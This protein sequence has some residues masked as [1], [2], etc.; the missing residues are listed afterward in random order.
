[1]K[2][3][4]DTNVLIAAFITRGVCSDLLEHCMRRHGL[5]TS[6]FILSEFHEQLIGKFKFSA[7]EVDEAIEL[8]R[9]KMEVVAPA[10]LASPICRDPDDDAVLGTAIPNQ[11]TCNA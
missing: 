8:L 10:S 6:Q 5:V 7:E 1:M 2:V 9:S 11:G 3:L 4:L